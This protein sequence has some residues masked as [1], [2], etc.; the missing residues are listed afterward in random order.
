MA[1][2]KEWEGRFQKGVTEEVIREYEQSLPPGSFAELTLRISGPDWVTIRQKMADKIEKQLQDDGYAPW[3]DNKRMVF[4]S[5]IDPAITVRWTV[6][7][8]EHHTGHRAGDFRT[9]VAAIPAFV[10]WI[11]VGILVAFF[12][13]FMINYYKLKARDGTGSIIGTPSSS[14]LI[15]ALGIAALAGYFAY[16][17]W[18]QKIRKRE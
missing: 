7:G 3:P 6:M 10:I 16:L 9:G 8:A 11:V 15:S 18:L 17:Y 12:A 13:A 2:I 1:V 14:S 4:C 5:L